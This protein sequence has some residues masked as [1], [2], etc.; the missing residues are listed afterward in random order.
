MNE[1]LFHF[2]FLL[3]HLKSLDLL[4]GEVRGQGAAG[5]RLRLSLLDELAMNLFPL[6]TLPEGF[7][8]RKKLSS[9]P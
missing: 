5:F 3:L 8:E 6:F 9:F 2:L 7:K 1:L 4:K